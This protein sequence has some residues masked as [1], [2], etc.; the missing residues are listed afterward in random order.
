MG[1]DLK[2]YLPPETRCDDVA[3]VVGL[4]LGCK[5]RL[6]PL[7]GDAVHLVVEGVS[8]KPSPAGL[9]SCA[10]IEVKAPGGYQHQILFHHEFEAPGYNPEGGPAHVGIIR[11]STPLWCGVA[12]RLV[13]FFGG[14]VDFNDHD[15][16]YEDFKVERPR[17]WNNP[18]DGEPWERFQR[19]MA[20]VQP[21]IHMPEVAAYPV[22]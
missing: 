11:R 17:P 4:A 2:C 21:A 15:D 14:S 5:G 8:L 7:G 19:E 13:D 6:E 10:V 12:K 16:S 9:A 3:K 20:A 1:V 18:C 22:R